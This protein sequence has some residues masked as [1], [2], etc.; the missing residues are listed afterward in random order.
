MVLAPSPHVASRVAT[1][2]EGD[3]GGSQ[4]VFL[5]P[6]PAYLRGKLGNGAFP[7]GVAWKKKKKRTGSKCLHLALPKYGS[8]VPQGWTVKCSVDSCFVITGQ[9]CSHFFFYSLGGK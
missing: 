7:C 8:K 1:S 6:V 4:G 3:A 2:R 5:E 9:F